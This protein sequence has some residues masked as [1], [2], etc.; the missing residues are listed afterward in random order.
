MICSFNKI[1]NILISIL[2]AQSVLLSDI[3]NEIQNVPIE[4]IFSLMNQPNICQTKECLT[5]G[6]I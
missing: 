4:S 5:Y 3:P 6:N 1:A 2:L